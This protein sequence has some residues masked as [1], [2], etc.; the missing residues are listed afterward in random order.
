[1][2]AASL[3]VRLAQ[4]ADHAAWRPLWD[5]YNAFY[6]RSGATALPDAITQTTW[7]RFFDDTEPMQAF[8]ALQ[9]ERMV[10]L[11][12]TLFHRSTTL[13]APT[14]YL[15]DLF[16][17]EGVRGQGVGAALIEA[18]AAHAKASGAARLYW[19]THE[20]NATAMRLYDRVAKKTGF[21]V[22]RQ[23]LA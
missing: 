21:L 4:P 16:T 1:M 7:A 6:G 2:P 11:A 22:Y 17:A 13:T 19:M 23:V 5:G 10:G 8:V 18:A 14:C 20:T 15:Q 9:G 12:H 3:T